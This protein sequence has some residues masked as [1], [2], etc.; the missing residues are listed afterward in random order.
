MII[1]LKIAKKD[2]EGNDVAADICEYL[3]S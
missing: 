3:P 2:M 1:D